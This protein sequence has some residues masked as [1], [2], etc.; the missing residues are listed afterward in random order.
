MSIYKHLVNN[1]YIYRLVIILVADALLFTQTNSHSVSPTILL[2]GF[3]LCI[4]TIYY[5]VHFLLF[6]L[7]FYG[8]KLT[9]ASQL[10][11]CAA[12]LGGL[13]LALQ[14]IG[15]LSLKDI[16]VIV[17]IIL[18]IYLYI[19]YNLPKRNQGD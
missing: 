13:L 17:P 11:I 16:A 18:L 15:E 7:S 12:G 14:S 9:H 4:A 10:A 19:T 2:L 3:I 5:I 1:K 8:I 6:L